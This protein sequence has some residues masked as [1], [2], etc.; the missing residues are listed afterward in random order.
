MQ[1]LLQFKKLAILTIAIVIMTI[2][3]FSSLHAQG[4][5][6]E[7]VLLTKIYETLE[8]INKTVT[9]LLTSFTE[10]KIAWTNKDETAET[11]TL[12]NLLSAYTQTLGNNIT[13]QNSLDQEGKKGQALQTQLLNDLFLGV[14]EIPNINYL[15]FQTLLKQNYTL[16]T[17]KNK[18]TNTDPAYVYIKNIAG[19]NI[20]HYP[21]WSFTLNK[22]RPVSNPQVYA[23]YYNTVMSIESFNAYILS[24]FYIDYVLNETPLTQQQ[25]ALINQAGKA[26]WFAQ[27]AA[28]NIGFVLRQLLTYESQVF[29]VLTELL[30]SIKQLLAAQA[31]TN[32]LL[33]LNN[34]SN[35]KIMFQRAANLPI[36]P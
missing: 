14:N 5:N 31:M 20:I 4:G 3:S 35:E 1:L 25:I 11:L 15:T 24:N 10:Y 34:Q 33:I 7:I 8:T 2:F 6:E 28:E 27:I 19:L 18:T 29:V 16:P 30:Q 17:D 21:P 22:N 36:T 12:N 23:N 32:T 13:V 26:D 9:A